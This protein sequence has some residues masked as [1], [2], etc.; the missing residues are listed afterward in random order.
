MAIPVRSHPADTPHYYV[1]GVLS[2]I[3]L[4]LASAVR[5]DGRNNIQIGS[6]IYAGRFIR[7]AA[8]YGWFWAFFV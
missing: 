4:G 2:D 1:A 8:G 3:M 7:H 5:I 6:E